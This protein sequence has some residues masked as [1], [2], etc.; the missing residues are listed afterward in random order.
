MLAHLRPVKAK[1]TQIVV[2]LTS[3]P[4]TKQH[5][6]CRHTCLPYHTH[7]YARPWRRLVTKPEHVAR[8]TIQDNRQKKVQLVPM[9]VL[10]VPTVPVAQ[11]AVV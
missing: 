3:R 7:Y 9:F 6:C 8:R 10:C 1:P 4:C 5:V 2:R 11:I